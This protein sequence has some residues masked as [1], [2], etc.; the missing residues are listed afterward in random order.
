MLR[1]KVNTLLER[2][3]ESREDLFLLEFSVDDANKIN[4]VIDGDR[5]VTVEDCI[6]ISRQIE[7]NLDREEEDF[8]LEV[9][10][11]GATAPLQ[12]LRQYEKNVGRQLEVRTKDNHYKAK[13]MN[14]EG[15][16]IQLAW[17]T[18]EPK[19]VGKGKVTVNKEV[20]LP[21]DE[22]EQAKVIITF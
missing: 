1:E 4:V 13:L 20:T 7:H 6:Y 8:S 19:P 5:G 12:L 17:K 21:I 15:E 22:I 10:S 16:S 11:A 18:R 9:K 2:A 3:L 14:V